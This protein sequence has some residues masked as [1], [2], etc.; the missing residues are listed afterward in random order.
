MRNR[1]VLT[2]NLQDP[3]RER[4]R[5]DTS[6]GLAP[7]SR[8]AGT[9]RFPV[10]Q[11]AVGWQWGWEWGSPAKA[12]PAP[13][14]CQ[15]VPWH[16]AKQPGKQSDEFGKGLYDIIGFSRG[17]PA[18]ETPWRRRCWLEFKI[19]WVSILFYMHRE[20]LNIRRLRVG[21]GG[22]GGARECSFL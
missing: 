16:R 7:S 21:G 12:H 14:S 8:S 17:F 2:Y 13:L 5:E 4:E 18:V 6:V 15:S 9:Q 20:C 22:R 10:W 3:Q 11:N 19:N 1:L